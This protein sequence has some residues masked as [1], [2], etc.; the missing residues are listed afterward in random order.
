MGHVQQAMTLAK[1]LRTSA[2]ISFLTKSE[3]SIASMLRESG[4]KATRLESDAA[5]LDNLAT[6][7]PQVIVFDKID[8]DENLAKRIK[9]SLSGALVIFTNLTD[10]NKYADVAVTADIG[11]RFD[12]V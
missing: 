5:I 3:E 9:T 6:M 12:N 1:Q 11:S 4:F 2:D 8:V 7:D 10:A